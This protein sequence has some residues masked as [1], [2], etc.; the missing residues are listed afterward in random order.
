[1]AGDPYPTP[2]PDEIGEYPCAHCGTPGV[3][4][5]ARMNSHSSQPR[6]CAFCGLADVHGALVLAD[7]TKETTTDAH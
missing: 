7:A 6:C 2:Q 1:M 4:C 5:L 3:D